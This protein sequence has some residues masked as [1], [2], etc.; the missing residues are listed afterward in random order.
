MRKNKKLLILTLIL[1]IGLNCF[2]L[3]CSLTKYKVNLSSSN[4][5]A[6]SV[7]GDGEYRVG[8]KIEIKAN[9]E[10]I[11]SYEWHG[12]YLNG[13]LYTTKEKFEYVVQ[14]KDISFVAMWQGITA[15]IYCY[16][17]IGNDYSHITNEDIILSFD[18]VNKNGIEFGKTSTLYGEALN[19]KGYNFV[20]W[21]SDTNLTNKVTESDGVLKNS[22]YKSETYLYAK[23]EIKNSKVSLASN[24]NL[25]TYKVYEYKDSTSSYEPVSL[26]NLNFDYGKKIKIEMENSGLDDLQNTY[27]S[28]TNDLNCEFTTDGA[29]FVYFDMPENDINFNVTF[30]LPSSG[31]EFDTTGTTCSLVNY[32]GTNKSVFIPLQ[33]NGKTVDTIGKTAFKNS[34]C[35]KVLINHK[36]NNIQDEA[37][38]G[39][40]AKIYFEEGSNFN[41]ITERCFKIDN[42]V[43]LDINNGYDIVYG[44]SLSY[45]NLKV[46][47]DGI[48]VSMMGQIADTTIND[49]QEFDT[50][51]KYVYLNNIDKEITWTIAFNGVIIDLTKFSYLY[52]SNLKLVSGGYTRVEG[53]NNAYK[54]LFSK[55][56]ADSSKIASIVSREEYDS[57]LVK[58][59]EFSKK[60]KFNNPS[61][62]LSIKDLKNP[63]LDRIV[64]VENFEQYMICNTSEQLLFAIESGCKPIFTDENC[65][66][67]KVYDKALNILKNIIDDTMTDYHKALAIHD[68]IIN[69]TVKDT[70]YDY[71][72][73][74]IGKKDAYLYRANFLEGA[75]IDNVANNF[76]YIKALSLLLSMEGVPN[77]RYINFTETNYAI[78]NRIQLENEDE[79]LVWYN[80]DIFKDEYSRNGGE[81]LGVIEFLTH[82]FFLINDEEMNYENPIYTV[83][84]PE[85]QSINSYREKYYREKEFVSEANYKLYFTSI[86]D[87]KL[88]T[89]SKAIL[90]HL[91]TLEYNT[92][93]SLEIAIEGKYTGTEILEKLVQKFGFTAIKTIEFKQ[94]DS[95]NFVT[96]FTLVLYLVEES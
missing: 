54:F 86:E 1:L 92:L 79:E 74:Q 47:V 65:S 51:F 23:W 80:I 68:Y 72:Q 24:S 84:E 27:E 19:V 75:L 56:D 78:W 52:N 58:D 14:S 6:G 32:F 64:A 83:K 35:E 88:D 3:G 11:G 33:F 81:T 77:T 89:T 45:Q 20:G 63:N 50:L 85:Y 26:D 59:S 39:V 91:K 5:Y 71:A 44:N 13:Q 16:S 9:S 17:D 31:F 90:N 49:Q 8:E 67:K 95:E 94:K 55:R 57:E 4:A 15:N 22:P 30:N 61:I 76:G 7:S 18:N 62:N 21:Y 40:K 48:S 28:W 10:D 42:E 69:T 66:A 53:V 73:K 36:I 34:S 41:L 25:T 96:I 93:Y 70:Y 29:R 38:Y 82:Q 37:F 46:L 43:F 12:W 2:H 60:V 87:E